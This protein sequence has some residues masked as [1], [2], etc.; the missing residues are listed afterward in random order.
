MK[1]VGP[2]LEELP[3]VAEIAHQ[4]HQL[5]FYAI[6]SA[7]VTVYHIIIMQWIE[8]VECKGSIGGIMEFRRD[9]V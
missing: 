2:K 3:V 6:A 7:N 4:L 5:R 9:R 8:L 1:Y